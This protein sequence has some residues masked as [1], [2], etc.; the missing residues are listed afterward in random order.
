MPNSSSLGS[1]IAPPKPIRRRA[2][3]ARP[4]L[5][6]AGKA[7]DDIFQQN[8]S[9]GGQ[10]AGLYAHL[11]HGKAAEEL[12]DDQLAVD[13]YDEVLA[14]AVDPSERAASTRLDAILA[15]AQYFRL[16]IIAKQNSQQFLSEAKDLAGAI[17]PFAADRRLPG[18][19][20]GACQGQAGGGQEGHRPGEGETHL[21]ALQILIEMAKIH[22]QYQRDAILLRREVLKAAG[23]YGRRRTHVRGGRGAGRRRR[24]P[25]RN[26]TAP[27]S[28]PQGPRQIARNR[29]R[30]DP[31]GDQSGAERPAGAVTISPA[32]CSKGKVERVHRRGRD[33]LRGP[34]EED[35]AG[36]AARRPRRR[37]WR[38]RRR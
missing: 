2:R 8:R 35:G 10:T 12:G 37:R 29:K 20:L 22:S 26:G 36:T 32:I 6:K 17:P 1:T 9:G 11:W 24:R 28:L 30:N 13:I 31:A 33:R 16:L 19:S 25:P 14:N 15:Q 5:Q 3:N 21:R 34:A 4:A 38:S 18:R 7:F 23:R 27:A